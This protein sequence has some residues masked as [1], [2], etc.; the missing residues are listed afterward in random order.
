MSFFGVPNVFLI[1]ATKLS[2]KNS[3]TNLVPEIS[4]TKLSNKKSEPEM[5][6]AL[7]TFP[8]ATL[9]TLRSFFLHYTHM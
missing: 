7:D 5:P 8:Y 6:R 3:G 9:L 2:N 1:S 4:A